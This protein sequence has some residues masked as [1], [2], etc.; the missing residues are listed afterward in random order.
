MGPDPKNGANGAMV[1]PWLTRL[2]LCEFP[3]S[4]KAS[5]KV[6]TLFSLELCERNKNHLHGTFNVQRPCFFSLRLLTLF[7]ILERQ[8][9]QANIAELHCILHR[10][11]ITATIFQTGMVCQGL[12][13]ACHCDLDA[14][15][16]LRHFEHLGKS[17]LLETWKLDLRRLRTP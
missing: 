4:T 2:S 8:E 9:S 16:S 7:I 5:G 1:E 15:R 3:I 13:V 6:T 14:H 12:N 10:D 17:Q 11:R